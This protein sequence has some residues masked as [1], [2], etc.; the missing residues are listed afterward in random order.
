MRY[1][2]LI[3]LLL[4]L[5]FCLFAASAAATT[6]DDEFDAGARAFR[7]QDYRQALVYFTRAEN[8]GMRE[9][10][11]DYNLGAVFYRLQQY[12]DSRRYF[13]KLQGHPTLGALAYYN[14]GLIAHKTGDRAGAIDWFEK[15]AGASA[16]GNLRALANQQIAKLGGHPPKPWFGYVSAAYGYDSNITLL[17]SS[18][19]A[20]ESGDFVQ[21]LALGEWTL[22]QRAAA[23]YHLTF[24]VLSTDF[25]DGSDF[26]DD[27]LTL[28]AE[29]R[30][31]AGDWRLDYGLE[32]GKSTFAGEDYTDTAAVAVNGRT[33]FDPNRE[34]RLGLTF[35][36]VSEGSSEFAFI[37]G[38]RTELAL[39][40]RIDADRREYRLE[41]AYEINDRENTDDQSFSPTYHRFRLRCFERITERVKLGASLEYRDA[42]YGGVSADTRRDE[43]S[44]LR[45]EGNY[46]L[47]RTWTTQAE[48]TYT[49]ND[50]SDDDSGYHK[51]QA[52]VSINALF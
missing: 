31:R 50:S 17:P 1:R 36:D 22:R 46:E 44:R 25:L 16:D 39:S 38:T 23:S 3:P 37:D 8:A 26:D 52:L 40:Y 42:D 18:S 32:F 33:R 12:D 41:Y 29:Y 6:A 21:L 30:R 5:P 35:E 24:L 45:L 19:A 9:P 14:L 47:D 15:C 20:D 28:G 13:E 48:L 11:L 10:R 2:L 49:D 7:A 51:Y 34:L 27:L 4:S 43:R